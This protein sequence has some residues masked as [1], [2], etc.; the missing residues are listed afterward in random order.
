MANKYVKHKT[1]AMS[2]KQK[3]H[4]LTQQC[5]SR[6]HNTCENVS[7]TRTVQILNEFMIDLKISGYSEQDR[8]KIL[9]G[10]INTHLK[11]KAKENKGTRPYYRPKLSVKNVMKKH[12]SSWFKGENNMYKTVMFVDATPNDEL[13]KMLRRTEEKFMIDKQHRIKLR[14][15][16]K[17]HLIIFT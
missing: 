7:T 8:K 2:L 12:K 13:L 16:L 1:S 6:I 11:L 17:C 4:I 3:M 10:G 15:H 5:F 9:E 14:W